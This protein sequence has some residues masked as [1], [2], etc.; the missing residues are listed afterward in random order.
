MEVR[1][2]FYYFFSLYFLNF[3]CIFSEIVWK[4]E[5]EGAS[6]TITS[7]IELIEI[8]NKLK[9]T[10]SYTAPDGYTIDKDE[11]RK[12]LLTYN[13]YGESPF[14][15]SSEIEK[16]NFISYELNPEVVGK[17]FL[18]F[19]NVLFHAKNKPLISFL[20]TVIP[21][22]S[23]LGVYNFVEGEI[24]PL[25]DFSTSIPL[26]LNKKNHTETGNNPIE[27]NVE[28]KKIIDRFAIRWNPILLF[29]F[30]LL[31]KILFFGTFFYKIYLRKKI[32]FSSSF[33]FNNYNETIL[34][35]LKNLEEENL[36]EKGKIE[37]YFQSLGHILRMYIENKWNIKT[38]SLTTYEFLNEFTQEN[39]G[40]NEIV[41]F[42]LLSDE[43]KFAKK[44][45]S[46]K[47]CKDAF[48]KVLYF[49]N[50]N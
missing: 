28:Q 37:E 31:L 34:I 36:P 19:G 10:L 3:H 47:I 24:A 26:S 25:L 39:I 23:S 16:S 42:L 43:I 2:Y 4:G 22:E 9:I 35:E 11:L 12:N 17:Y 13:G 20:T 41:T 29:I 18:S 38:S 30:L 7:S 21:V 50:K 46:K 44:N 33:F 6:V 15:L 40:Y 49:I 5:K 45:V 27:Q 8:P 1:K 14:S 32:N 48:K